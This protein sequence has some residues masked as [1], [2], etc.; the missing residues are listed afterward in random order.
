M[1]QKNKR[2]GRG[3]GSGRGRTAGRGSKGQRSRSGVKSRVRFEGG[4]TPLTIRLPKQRGF[5]SSRIKPFALTTERLN[6][7]YNDSETIS[8]D[9][10]KQKKIIA[11]TIKSVKIIGSEK[12]R[13]NI[14]SDS[15]I[16]FSR[17]HKTNNEVS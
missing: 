1:P 12:L 2:I 3:V 14:V 15:R 17:R 5:H 9:S 16:L 13:A 7:L 8:F 11:S 6:Q 10:L 4:Q